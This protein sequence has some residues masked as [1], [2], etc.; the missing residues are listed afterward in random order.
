M[1]DDIKVALCG[2]CKVALQGPA[3]P[4]P[5]SVFTCPECGESD[6]YENVVRIAGEFFHEQSARFL[7]EKARSVAA[8]SKFITF[9]GEPIPKRQHRFVV[10][11]EF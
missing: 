10:D 6:T 11:L 4:E 2:K 1:A 5:E 7:Q 9:K 3:Q 8:G